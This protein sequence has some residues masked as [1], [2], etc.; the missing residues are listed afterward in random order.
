[1][2]SPSRPAI[3]NDRPNPHDLLW[4]RSEKAIARKAFVAALKRELHKVIQETER[5]ASQIKPTSGL[6]TGINS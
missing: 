4:S 6:P 2:S 5:I 3:W 1:M